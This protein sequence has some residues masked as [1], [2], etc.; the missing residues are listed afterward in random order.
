MEN[1]AVICTKYGFIGSHTV[2]LKSSRLE[3]ILPEVL[4]AFPNVETIDAMQSVLTL[5]GV[6]PQVGSVKQ[7]ELQNALLEGTNKPLASL[8]KQFPNVVTLQLNGATLQ[9]WDVQGLAG[10]TSLRELNLTGCD[11]DDE[12]LR[13]LEAMDSLRVLSLSG[14]AITNESMGVLATLTKLRR[15]NVYRT[16]MDADTVASLRTF[17]PRCKIYGAIRSQ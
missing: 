11:I 16:G 5:G 7:L 6:V 17:L 14:T 10:L 1:P 13:S 15:L 9:A 8:A 4:R 2:I 12:A 3:N